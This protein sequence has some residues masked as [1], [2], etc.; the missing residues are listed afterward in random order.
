MFSG[1]CKK[2][3]Y[4]NRNA[5][6][7]LLLGIVVPE[8]ITHIYNSNNNNDFRFTLQ[9]ITGTVILF[10]SIFLIFSCI[11]G[12]KSAVGSEKVWRLFFGVISL[13]AFIYIGFA[14]FMQFA[15]RN[16]SIG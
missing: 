4:S 14:L 15:L 8:K 1:R 9:Y 13:A 16:I 2:I 11:N 6:V 7:V 5:L 3:N 12:F 10:S